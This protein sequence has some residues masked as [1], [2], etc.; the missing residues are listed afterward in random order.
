MEYLKSEYLTAKIKP[1]DTFYAAPDN[2]GKGFV[3]FGKFY[4]R[5]YFKHLPRKRDIRVL[6]ISC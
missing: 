1:F 2:I 4:Q 5:S 6:V 3:S